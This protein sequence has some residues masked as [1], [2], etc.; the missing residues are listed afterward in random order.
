MASNAENVS[1]WWR[2]HVV[3][4]LAKPTDRWIYYLEG[5]SVITKVLYYIDVTTWAPWRLI[6][7]QLNG[8]FNSLFRL[9]LIKENSALPVICEGRYPW[10]LVSRINGQQ[11]GKRFNVVPSSCFKSFYN[12]IPAMTSHDYFWNNVSIAESVSF[13][14]M[15]N[16]P[17][18]LVI[19]SLRT[20]GSSTLT[21]TDFGT[22]TTTVSSTTT[23]HHV[24]MNGGILWISL[25]SMNGILLM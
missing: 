23:S 2:H 13:L 7:S 4:S 9:T 20:L 14:L 18:V 24:R 25:R 17:I 11:C 5:Q 15:V 3:L 16:T 6:S 19:T 22:M 21:S 12:H 1:I 10:L 8:F